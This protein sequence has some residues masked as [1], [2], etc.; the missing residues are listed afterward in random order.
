[1]Q[2]SSPSSPPRP[3]PQHV[4]QQETG[5]GRSLTPEISNT[6][7]SSPSA[8]YAGLTLNGDS[9]GENSS[10]EL[11]GLHESTRASGNWCR[12]GDI[13]G[14][15]RSSSPAKRTSS[16]M[17]GASDT[18]VNQDADMKEPPKSCQPLE[19]ASDATNL[20]NSDELTSKEPSTQNVQHGTGTSVSTT[21]QE[22]ITCSRAGLVSTTVED[23]SDAASTSAFLTPQSGIFSHGSA[24][25]NTPKASTTGSTL[26]V[27]S[28]G[29]PSIDDQITQVMGLATEP[30]R[31]GQKGYVVANTWLSRVLSRGTEAKKREQHTK[32]A[33]DGE[34]GPVDNSGINLVMEPASIRLED[35]AGDP[36]IPL[37]PG[38]QISEDFE[39]V[40]P[41]AW[42]LMV[43]WYGLAQGSPIITRYCHNTNTV[44]ATENLQYEL[45]PPVFTIVKLP[46]RVT[47]G[48]TAQNL[49]EKDLVPIQMLASRREV[50]QKFLKRAK[51]AADIKL[52]T[53]VRVWRILSGLSENPPPG[54]LTPAQSRS[55]SPTP[56]AVAPINPGKSLVVDMNVFLA[57]Q[58]GSQRELVDAKDETANDKY[59]GSSTLD[60]VGLSQDEVIVLEEQIGG[61]AGGEWV[62]DVACNQAAKY[63]VPI[64]V[65]KQGVTTVQEN[66]KPK[67]NLSNGRASPAPSAGGIMTRG[68][69]QKNGRA[70][71]TIGLG[72]L[73][74]TC[75]MNSALQCVRSVEELTT[76]FLRKS[77]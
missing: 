11:G 30:L 49:N 58:Q 14:I 4:L 70:R 71:G 37:K 20:L 25:L 61:P 12:L 72:N 51:A 6:T 1:M 64:S 69:A 32:A 35:E 48:V 21:T 34:I 10:S 33:M 43:E 42:E 17:D 39:I 55:A 9:Q 36:F 38:L 19:D 66:L 47:A 52:K 24:S 22:G 16:E 50:F 45:N 60:L 44:G 18:H 54:M 3:I 7:A 40:P 67:S 15:H 5:R 74:N 76:Y 59:N 26:L 77:S 8:A 2:H 62:S 23:G 68:R 46:D 73:G 29:V 53:K 63:G 13:A 28:H 41:N 57:L 75:Y 65:T 27:N 31:D 56:N